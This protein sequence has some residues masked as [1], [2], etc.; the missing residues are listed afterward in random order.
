MLMAIPGW[1]HASL[2]DMHD[3]VVSLIEGAVCMIFVGIFEETMFRGIFF[4]FVEQSM[5]TWA[6]LA[7]T[8]ICFGLVHIINPAATLFGAL[9]ISVEAGLMIGGALVYTRSMWS[10]IGIHAAWNLFQGINVYIGICS[11]RISVILIDQK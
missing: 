7:I 9:C 4:E 10:P 1:Y 8:S 11:A 3:I 2:S 6:A 5:G